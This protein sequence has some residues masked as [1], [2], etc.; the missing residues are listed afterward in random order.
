[1]AHPVEEVALRARGLGQLA[2]A[3]GQLPGARRD[4]G[5]EP[6]A[7]ARLVPPL[8]LLLAQAVSPQAE[9]CERIPRLRPGRCPR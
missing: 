7:L 1:M 4:L 8:E 3:L 2:I 6:L 5:F 9:R